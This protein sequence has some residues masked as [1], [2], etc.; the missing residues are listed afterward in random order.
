[1]ANMPASRHTSNLR[2]SPVLRGV[3]SGGYQNG[4]VE[5]SLR[6]LCQLAPFRGLTLPP[7]F[8]LLAY[9]VDLLLNTSVSTA[10]KMSCF[11]TGGVHI[12][13]TWTRRRDK[14]SVRTLENSEAGEHVSC[15]CAF[16]K[17]QTLRVYGLT[18]ASG[19]K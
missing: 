4:L 6:I 3:A 9:V 11:G 17:K 13:Q 18:V 8:R 14:E 19:P 1:M 16:I 10:F 7:F 15:Y 2:S 5:R 12:R